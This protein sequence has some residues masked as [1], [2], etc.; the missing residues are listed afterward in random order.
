MEDRRLDI[1]PE[2][3]VIDV[4]KTPLDGYPT[5]SE[6]SDVR[7]GPNTTRFERSAVRV[8]VATLAGTAIVSS[9]GLQDQI[10]DFLTALAS[11]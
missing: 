8:L 9:R 6:I 11:G 7:L 3:A 5:S 1:N 2:S 4:A 10:A